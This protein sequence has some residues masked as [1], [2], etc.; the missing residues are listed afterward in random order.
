MSTTNKEQV[1]ITENKMISLV[2]DISLLP[3]IDQYNYSEDDYWVNISNLLGEITWTKAQNKTV[4]TSEE[5]TEEEIDRLIDNDNNNIDWGINSIWKL[6]IFIK[7]SLTQTPIRPFYINID[8]T[9]IPSDIIVDIKEI[10]FGQIPIGTRI[11]KTI[12]IY[13]NNSNDIMNL[14]QINC[15]NSIGPFTILNSIRPINPKSFISLTIECLPLYNGIYMDSLSVTSDIC[16]H[17][18][19]V[20]IK[21]YG[22]KPSIEINGLTTGISNNKD[23]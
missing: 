14:K 9:V 19:T 12:K 13:N 17:I 11:L 23:Y 3:L 6:P 2:N 18:I 16:T 20:P 7:S 1:N 15:F 22:I 4:S 10:D 5:I 21:V 8:T